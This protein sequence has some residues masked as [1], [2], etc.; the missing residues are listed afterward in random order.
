MFEVPVGVDYRAR[1]ANI[2][3]C[4]MQVN[5]R[6]EDG[7]LVRLTLQYHCTHHGLQDS[8]IPEASRNVCRDAGHE[9]QIYMEG[10]GVAHAR[11]PVPPSECP[12]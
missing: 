10:P 5:K 6:I 3:V 1:L 4:R 11:G 2:P 9:G 7:G 12:S 8:R